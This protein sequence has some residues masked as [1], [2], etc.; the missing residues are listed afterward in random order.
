[1]TARL[2][3]RIQAAGRLREIDPHT[4]ATAIVATVIALARDAVTG[5]QV[6]PITDLETDVRALFAP[7]L[8]EE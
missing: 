3:S 2:A 5:E 1:L 4:L 6:R 7:V 8:R